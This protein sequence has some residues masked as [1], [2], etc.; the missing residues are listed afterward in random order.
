M[1][2]RQ[3]PVTTPWP[4]GKVLFRE[5]T[6]STMEDARRLALEGAPSGTTAAAGWQEQGRGRFP[7]RAW[8]SPAGQSLLFTVLLR[9][10]LG[11][12]RIRLPLLAGLAVARTLEARFGL[13]PALKWPNDVLVDGR[14]I[15]G[16]LCEAI[17]DTVL[18]GVGLNVNQTAFP[19]G[20]GRGAV[21]LRGLVGRE[22]EP[23]SLLEPVLEQL[24]AALAD[25]GWREAIEERL[26]LRKMP[27]R[28]VEGA[29]ERRVLRGQL[30]GLAPDGALLLQVAGGATAALY[31]GELAADDRDSPESGSSRSAMDSSSR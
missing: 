28:F 4:G 2:A 14:K 30:L 3:L 18:V 29:E 24:A 20:L 6:A 10:P 1:N 15:C 11:V 25:A 21:S 12:P 19:A 31:A 13:R 5:R 8:Q 22:E 26:Y 27:V 9:E 17:G 7:G 23:L 16:V